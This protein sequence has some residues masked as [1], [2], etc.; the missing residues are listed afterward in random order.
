MAHLFQDALAPA[1]AL[2]RETAIGRNCPLAERACI[3]LARRAIGTAEGKRVLIIGVGEASRLAGLALRDAGAASIVIANRTPANAAELARELDAEVAPLDN[4]ASLI[5]QADLAVTATAAPDFILSASLIEEAAAR[6]NGTP[7]A[8]MDM[9]VRARRRSPGPRRF[10]GSRLYAGRRGIAGG[11]QT[12]SS[13]KPRPARWRPSSADGRRSSGIG[14]SARRYPDHRGD[15][16]TMPKRYAQPKS[17]GPWS[18]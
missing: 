18:A 12:G 5:A 4:L 16:P 1:S 17:L 7:L 2:V 9:A 10:R 13:V 11:G 15:T 3:E 14:G 8:I 6:R